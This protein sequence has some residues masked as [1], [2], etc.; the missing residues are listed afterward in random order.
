[1]EKATIAAIPEGALVKEIEFKEY[2]TDRVQ[3]DT[4]V[5]KHIHDDG[6]VTAELF[7][8]G[9]AHDPAVT[10]PAGSEILKL[11]KKEIEAFFAGASEQ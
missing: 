3:F 4:A 9:D 7:G 5:I 2:G 11:T 8:P 6:S 10:F 1:M